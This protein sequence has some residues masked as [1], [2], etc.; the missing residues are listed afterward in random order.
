MLLF[1][2]CAQDSE[3]AA[4]DKKRSR[5]RPILVA[6]LSFL[7]SIVLMAALA[8]AIPVTLVR[9]ILTDHNIEVI[10]DH[11][12]DTVDIADIQISTEDGKKTVAEAVLDY[13]SEFEGLSFITEEQI[14]EVLLGDFTKEIIS[15]TLKQYSLL[16]KGENGTLDLTPEGIYSFIEENKDTLQALARESGYEGEIPLEEYKDEMLSALESAIGKE[17]ISTDAILG[18]SE[19]TEQLQSFLDRAQLIFSDSALWLVWGLVTFIALLLLFLNIKFLGSFCRACG[20][21]AFIVGGLYTLA[22]FAAQT[23]LAMITIEN[24]ILAELVRFT[25]GFVAALLADIALPAVITGLALI[26]VSFVLDIL[27]K[28]FTKA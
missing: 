11:V 15:N 12:S 4:P 20:F 25:V 17:G 16:L 1:S 14:N 13:T 10:V 18:I 26:I 19:Q 2:Q 24:E 27:R 3:E 8:L 7:L 23:L 9:F 22:A 21:P 28:I 5:R 6:I